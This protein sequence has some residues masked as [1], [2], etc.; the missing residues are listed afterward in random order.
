MIVW[1]F[2]LVIFKVTS[3][4]SWQQ[5]HLPILSWNSIHQYFTQYSFKATSCF[6][7]AETM[8]CDERVIN[9]IAKT[10]FDPRKGNLGEKK[11]NP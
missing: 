9:P 8:D 7:I 3:V 5:M 6:P 11:R 2:T 10:I 1:C 4:I